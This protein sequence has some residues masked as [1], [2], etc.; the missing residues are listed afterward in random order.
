MKLTYCLKTP[1][2]NHDTF[3]KIFTTWNRLEANVIFWLESYLVGKGSYH[4]ALF[5]ASICSQ[6]EAIL[7]NWLSAVQ[8]KL[9]YIHETSKNILQS[10]WNDVKCF[11][12]ILA[13]IL[14]LKN[15]ILAIFAK[16]TYW[17]FRN[18][19]WGKSSFYKLENCQTINPI[20]Y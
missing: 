3:E 8:I 15:V 5:C 20:E 1:R 9:K 14:R 17:W 4:L 2:P 11:E 6:N 10:S 7:H 19:Y 16:I 18:C 13:K 12:R